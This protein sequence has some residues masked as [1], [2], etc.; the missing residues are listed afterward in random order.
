MV[1]VAGLC[2]LAACGGGSGGNEDFAQKAKKLEKRACACHDTT[3]LDEIYLDGQA[4]IES[5]SDKYQKKANM[6][7]EMEQAVDK[8]M[9]GFSVCLRKV[10]DQFP[11]HRMPIP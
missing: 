5:L 1:V 10:Q 4:M 9:Y 11:D 3:C 2:A 6:P 8:A 7:P